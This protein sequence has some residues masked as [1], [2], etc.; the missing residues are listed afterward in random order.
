MSW[1]NNN[2]TS[3]IDATQIFEGGSGNIVGGD[4]NGTG[5]SSVL[6]DILEL[7]LDHF[8]NDHQNNRIGNYSLYMLAQKI[9][10]LLT[11]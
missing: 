9:L 11:I 7:K 5:E 1:Y 8:E 2:D 6:S 3:F 4:G 10:Y